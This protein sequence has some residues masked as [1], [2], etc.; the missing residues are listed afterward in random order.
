M[1]FPEH[2][3]RT[4]AFVL[5]PII[6]PR[7]DQTLMCLKQVVWIALEESRQIYLLTILAHENR[8]PAALSEQ[9]TISLTRSK[10]S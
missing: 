1:P 2:L 5:G 10:L 7:C 9:T 6:K 3:L 8:S 4:R